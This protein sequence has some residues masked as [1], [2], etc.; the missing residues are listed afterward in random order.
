MR[1]VLRKSG[2]VFSSRQT[3]RETAGLKHVQTL[4]MNVKTMQARKTLTT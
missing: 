2:V 1:G 3:G 4:Q